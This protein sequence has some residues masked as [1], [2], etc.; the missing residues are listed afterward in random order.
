MP[1]ATGMFK[2]TMAASKIWQ[3]IQAYGFSAICGGRNFMPRPLKGIHCEFAIHRI[4]VRNEDVF[5]CTKDCHTDFQPADDM[6][7]NA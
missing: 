3:V 7:Q 2:S 1:L 6:D 5:L 4:I